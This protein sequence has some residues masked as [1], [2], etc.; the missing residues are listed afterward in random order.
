MLAE[1][2][3]TV[4]CVKMTAVFAAGPTPDACPDETTLALLAE[5]ALAPAQVHAVEGHVASCAPCRELL[6]MMG[7]A[8]E[9]TG[10]PPSRRELSR[11]DTV[12]RHVVLERV[13][14]G[15]MGVVYAAYDPDLDRRVAL[16]LLRDEVLGSNDG[17][18]ARQRMVREAKALA[19]LAHPNVVTVYEVS[20]WCG[21]VYLSLEFVEGLDL[22]RWLAT[23]RSP[24]QILDVVVQAGRGLAAAHAARLIHRDFKPA[25]VLIGADGRARVADFGLARTHATASIRPR[26]P[27]P[28]SPTHLTDAD[29]LMGTPAYMAPEQ[30]EGAYVDHRADQF[31]FCVTLYEALCGQRPFANDGWSPQGL[32]A[33]GE[34]RTPPRGRMSP[35]IWRVV[36]RGLDLRPALRFASMDALL[37]ALAPPRARRWGLVVG[38][39]VA[40]L[41]IAALAWTTLRPVEPTAAQLA[42]IEGLVADAHTAADD[43]RYLYPPP[44]DPTATT[45]Y[46]AVLALERIDDDSHPAASGRARELREDLA[47]HLAELGR[48]Y[49][50][51]P[52]TRA[53]AIDFYVAAL[54]FDP[55]NGDARARATLSPGE[56]ATLRSRAAQGEFTEAELWGAEPLAALAEPDAEQRDDRLRT[57]ATRPRRRR[58]RATQDHDPLDALLEA[59]DQPLDMMATAEPAPIAAAPVDPVP[60]VP[61]EA[62]TAAARPEAA[63]DPA[64]AKTLTSAGARA[65]KAGRLDEAAAA[66]RDA[67][68]HDPNHHGA[69]IGLG[70]VEFDR[71]RYPQAIRFARRAVG[72]APRR[73]SYRIKLG[74]ALFAD[75]QYAEAKKEYERARSLGSDRAARRLVRVDDKLR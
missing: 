21:Q 53:Y 1:R 12:G 2:R 17:D 15:G 67:L 35:Q 63:R 40:L 4:R 64:R 48:N 41:G 32:V 18:E 9:V 69:L 24:E 7:R 62:P 14:A 19:R 11:G 43:E 6:A 54:V 13:G 72:R 49:W 57:L 65:L 10:V 28:G 3:G 39:L 70:D 42:I 45:A 29:Q 27:G 5:G 25:N 20:T 56:L 38:L 68:V 31:A 46:R 66:F 59:F 36:K 73:A 50:E 75:Y 30:R 22:I 26:P 74:D 60:A 37:V 16:K 47:A 44:D 23:P 34:P 33:L 51:Q 8:A 52:G 58:A 71:G 55:D 61:I